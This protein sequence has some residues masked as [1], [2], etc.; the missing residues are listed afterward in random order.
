MIIKMIFSFSFD[1]IRWFKAEGVFV[2]LLAQFYIQRFCWFIISNFFSRNMNFML[3]RSQK[4]AF[5]H[6]FPHKELSQIFADLY[7]CENEPQGWQRLLNEALKAREAISYPTNFQA[8]THL[9]F[10]A[11]QQIFPSS[12]NPTERE[13]RQDFY[14]KCNKLWN[15][16]AVR[17]SELC[18]VFLVRRNF[19]SAHSVR[20]NL[21]R[22]ERVFD[23]H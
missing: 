19:S 16:F 9:L 15:V 8:S 1:L 20:C 18:F 23:L 7:S 6:Q 12:R 11:A 17:N 13:K 14:A 2:F 22:N 21:Y 5:M 4:F 3:S 10:F